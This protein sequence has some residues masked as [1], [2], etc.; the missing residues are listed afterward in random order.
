[1]AETRITPIDPQND[2]RCLELIGDFKL[3]HH[4]PARNLDESSV[5]E[6]AALTMHHR[7]CEYLP[8]NIPRTFLY[9]LMWTSVCWC[10]GANNSVACPRAVIALPSASST[11]CRYVFEKTQ[12]VYTV[13]VEYPAD[14]A[15]K[16]IYARLRQEGWK[17]LKRDFLNPSIPSSDVRGWQ[18]FEDDTTQPKTTVRAWQT[19]WVNQQ[20]DIVDYVLEYRYPVSGA[21]DLHT[22]RVVALFI[23]ADVAAKAQADI[24]NA[25]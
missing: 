2:A 9:V 8:A 11:T 14:G 19:Q 13:D 3:G 4:P 17:P 18:Q 7:L 16:T 25:R 15:L 21:P 10:Q 12:L 20:K 5:R 1:M 24:R 23:R 22:L 6:Y